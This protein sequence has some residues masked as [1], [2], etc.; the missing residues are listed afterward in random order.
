[1]TKKMH[2][3]L[4]RFSESSILGRR[5]PVALRHVFQNRMLGGLAV[6]LIAFP[7]AASPAAIE[8]DFSDTLILLRL[9]QLTA[10]MAQPA[11]SSVILA[12]QVEAYLDAARREGDPRFLGYAGRLLQSW[13][14]TEM[15]GRLY[16]L[17]AT[18][19]Q[20][21]HLFDE[22]RADLS[23][24]LNDRSQQVTHNQALLI[25]ANMELVQG[26]YAQAKLACKKVEA[27]FPGLIASSC[28]ALVAAR[29]GNAETAYQNLKQMTHSQRRQPGATECAWAEGTLADLA[30]Q[31]DRPEAEDHWRRVLELSPQDLY[32]RGQFTDW[33]IQRQRYAEAVRL[34]AGYEQIDSLAVLRAIALRKTDPAEAEALISRLQERFE[35]ARWRGN[36]LH[37]RDYARFLLDIQQQPAAALKYAKEN[38]QQQREPMDT[39]ILLR[40]AAA[41]NSAS[42][43]KATRGWLTENQQQD[44][45]YPEIRP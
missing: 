45:R 10:S 38:W 27:R 34:S 21:L 19:R 40:A 31:L 3:L 11:K 4:M 37:Q 26:R 17:R 35:E 2:R 41:A 24:V 13:P 33:L 18:L 12:S 36:F 42:L 29:S 1:M 9:P 23:R 16:L 5:F 32:S 15:S 30:S 44:A 8:T 43:L 6:L 39:R 7:L 25:L 20:S 22:A 28:S 14:E